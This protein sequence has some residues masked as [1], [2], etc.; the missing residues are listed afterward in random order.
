[1]AGCIAL[2]LGRAF[3]AGEGGRRP[4]AAAEGTGRP[5][6]EGTGRPV[7][8]GLARP[9]EPTRLAAALA[10]LADRAI[11]APE[12]IPRGE[13]IGSTGPGRTGEAIAGGGAI[14]APEAWAPIRALAPLESSTGAEGTLSPLARTVAAALAGAFH[15]AR[16]GTVDGAIRRTPGAIPGTLPG[17][18]PALLATSAGSGGA[19]AAGTRPSRASAGTATG[20]GTTPLRPRVEATIGWGTHGR[21]GRDPSGLAGWLRRLEGI[22]Q[23]GKPLRIA[24]KQP[25]Q[26]R[27]KSRG[28]PIKSRVGATGTAAGAVAATPHQIPLPLAQQGLKPL[29]GLR[30]GRRAHAPYHG[31]VQILRTGRPLAVPLPLVQLPDRIAQPGQLQGGKVDTRGGGRSG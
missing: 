26:H 15:R 25:S 28:L 24:Q 6:A 21:R 9:S 29:Q 30:L 5:I 8:E 31:P 20:A 7:T 12:A 19:E 18:L 3:A 13:T 2:G 10:G 27:L 4:F 1:M 14:G 17:G 11:G 22:E 23:F 16:A